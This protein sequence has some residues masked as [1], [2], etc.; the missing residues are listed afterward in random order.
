M[1]ASHTYLALPRP[2]PPQVLPSDQVY[3]TDFGDLVNFHRQ[4]LADITIVC[5]E[6][7]ESKADKFGIVKVGQ[8]GVE[9][10]R[11]ERQAER[12]EFELQTSLCC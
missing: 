6:V 10:G 8:G 11:V 9:K 5:H 4:S 12:S 7:N 3:R 2:P 1:P